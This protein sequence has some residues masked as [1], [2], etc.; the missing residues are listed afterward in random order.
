[1]VQKEPLA[2]QWEKR[3]SIS[4]YS[5]LGFIKL[6]RRNLLFY[7]RGRDQCEILSICTPKS[8]IG[9]RLRRDDH[10]SPRFLAMCVPVCVLK[11]V[12]MQVESNICACDKSI[13]YHLVSRFSASRSVGKL[14]ESP[15]PSDHSKRSTEPYGRFT[16]S[17]TDR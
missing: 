9:T 16:S 7:G 4:T 1:M 15:V 14:D 17:K 8:G 13:P 2:S 12:D 6:D 11:E 10:V 3:I 5:A